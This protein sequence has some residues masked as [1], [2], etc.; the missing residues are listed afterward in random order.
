MNNKLN[1]TLLETLII[2][3]KPYLIPY[4]YRYIVDIWLDPRLTQFDIG[5]IAKRKRSK[6]AR[7]DQIIVRAGGQQRYRYSGKIIKLKNHHNGINNS[8]LLRNIVELASFEISVP[9]FAILATDVF[10]QKH[11]AEKTRAHSYHLRKSSPV[12]S[13]SV[14]NYVIETE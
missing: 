2:T 1:Q 13:K 4:N 8:I 9:V 12:K 11:H 7:S 14:F 3:G 5:A 10:Y 6:K